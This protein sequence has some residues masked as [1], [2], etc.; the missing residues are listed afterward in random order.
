MLLVIITSINGVPIR[1]TEERW[2]HIVDEKPYM[3]SYYE[4]MLDAVEEPDYILR[5]NAG[6]LIAVMTLGKRKH[7]HTVYRE[8]SKD[9]GFIITAFIAEKLNKGRIIWR[10]K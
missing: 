8:L 2:E 9:D 6:S 7:M 4:Q 10:K 1:L 3:Q 5:G